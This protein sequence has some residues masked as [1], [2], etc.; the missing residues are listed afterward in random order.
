M[1]FSMLGQESLTYEERWLLNR[2]D[3][4]GRFDYIYNTFNMWN[5]EIDY[6]FILLPH[7]HTHTHT[8]YS[9]C[10]ANSPTSR[11]EVCFMNFNKGKDD[12]GSLK[13]CNFLK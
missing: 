7:T 3:H 1:P 13:F 2:G 5:F 9:A 12:E 8:H 11:L 10:E 4:M 6:L